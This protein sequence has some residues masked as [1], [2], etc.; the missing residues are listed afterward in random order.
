[1]PNQPRKG[2]KQLTLRMDPP[3]YEAL[4]QAAAF[5]RRSMH[6]EM[7]FLLEHQLTTDG[8]YDGEGEFQQEMKL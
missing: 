3:M 7:L 4:R 2:I 6:S 5:N 1:M 8:F